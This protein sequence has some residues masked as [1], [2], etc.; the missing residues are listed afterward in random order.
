MIKVSTGRGVGRWP[1]LQVRAHYGCFERIGLRRRSIICFLLLFLFRARVIIASTFV[2]G[3][4][5]LCFPLFRAHGRR[6]RRSVEVYARNAIIIARLVFSACNFLIYFVYNIVYV[7]VTER[8]K[9]YTY[10]V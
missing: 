3:I 4:Y 9:Q 2:V 1:S 10:I 8:F 6:R 5:T 7:F